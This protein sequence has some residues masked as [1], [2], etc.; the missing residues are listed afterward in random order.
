MDPAFQRLKAALEGNSRC[1]GERV[2]AHR[3]VAGGIFGPVEMQIVSVS[4]AFY[5]ARS[6]ERRWQMPP[7]QKHRA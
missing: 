5:E 3:A 7:M 6:I 4:K 2:S 1:G